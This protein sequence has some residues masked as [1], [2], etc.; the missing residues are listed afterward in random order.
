MTVTVTSTTL[1]LGLLVLALLSAYDWTPRSL[2]GS[3]YTAFSRIQLGQS[4][5]L[6]VSCVYL[7]PPFESR[8]VDLS[9]SSEW[10][11]DS[12]DL[13]NREEGSIIYL[14]LESCD[15]A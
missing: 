11:L 8:S 6:D 12:K 10:N 3:R 2:F 14:A 9:K 13:H 15:S 7:L 1:K 5:K 4:I